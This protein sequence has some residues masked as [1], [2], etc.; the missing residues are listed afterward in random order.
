MQ[1]AASPKEHEVDDRFEDRED[2]PFLQ[3]SDS[4]APSSPQERDRPPSS[5]TQNNAVR[6]KLRI[7]LMITLFAIILFVETGNAMTSGPGTRIF[8]AIACRN[9]FNETDPSKLGP[10]G[11]V[12]EEDCKIP[13]VQGEIAIIKG[14]LELFDG[15]ASILLALPYGLLADRIGRKPT[16][17]LAV[18]GFVLNILMQGCVLWFSD[19]FPLRA[20]WLSSLSWLFG[21]GVVVAAAV[22][23]T[24]MTDVTTEAQRSVFSLFRYILPAYNVS[25]K[26][27]V[28]EHFG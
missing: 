1:A 4:A 8:E 26:L 15:V 27:A 20:I 7:R 9:F 28:A 11:Q 19:I 6:E 21:G 10:D 24:M 14:Y 18:P 3:R 13:E 2:A 22:I 16:I 17:L 23:W 5:H 12:P 25:Y